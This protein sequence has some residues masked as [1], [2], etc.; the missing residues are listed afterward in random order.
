MTLATETQKRK[1]TGE[2]DNCS[3]LFGLLTWSFSCQEL[4]ARWSQRVSVNQGLDGV[5]SA[6]PRVS[7]AAAGGRLFLE[8]LSPIH[9]EDLDWL[10][11]NL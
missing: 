4:R 5:A 1:R 9:T 7:N 6:N 2:I 11:A 3:G 10:A 8:S